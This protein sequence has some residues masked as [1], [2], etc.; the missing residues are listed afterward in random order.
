MAR[1]ARV[2]N[3]EGGSVIWINENHVTCIKEYA[4]GCMIGFSSDLDDVVSVREDIDDIFA[5]WDDW[6]SI[7]KDG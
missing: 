2:T 5:A 1:W 4:N 6:Q 7:H 3:I